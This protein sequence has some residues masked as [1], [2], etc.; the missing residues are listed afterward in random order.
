MRDKIQIRLDAQIPNIFKSKN[1]GTEIEAAI[2]AH[3]KYG[4]RY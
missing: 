2:K 1:K 4:G 3:Q